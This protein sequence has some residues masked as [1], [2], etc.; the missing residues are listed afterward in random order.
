MQVPATLGARRLYLDLDGVM[1][2]FDAHF[3]ALFG[4]DHRDLLDAAMWK[5]ITSH[6]SFF[7]TM[8]VCAGALDFFAAIRHL[9]PIIL[10]A[11]PKSDYANV[12]RQKR[13]WV[14]EHLGTDVMVLP[15]AGGTAKPMFMHEPGDILIDDFE[16]NCKAWID[17]GGVS[18]L[19]TSFDD[20][21]EQLRAVA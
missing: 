14:R 7:R 11:C 21:C 6:G 2:D 3:P 4:V 20:T 5:Q 8:P 13:E 17:H 9:Q 12:A 1:A 16:R 18:I 15:S 10:T 19:H